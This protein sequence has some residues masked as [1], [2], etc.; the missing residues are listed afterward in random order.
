MKRLAWATLF[1]SGVSFGAVTE[2]LLSDCYRYPSY[3]PAAI[4]YLN[5]GPSLYGAWYYD[6]NFRYE[7]TVLLVDA[8]GRPACERP[9]VRSV[10]QQKHFEINEAHGKPAHLERDVKAFLASQEMGKCP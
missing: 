4:R 7:R 10:I 1:L 9:V 3:N 5:N 2:I 6:L 8:Y